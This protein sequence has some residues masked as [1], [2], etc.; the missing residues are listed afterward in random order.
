M[1]GTNTSYTVK[2]W[3]GNKVAMEAGKNI[4]MCEVFG[5]IKESEKA[6]YAVLNIGSYS[7]KTMW[8]PKSVLVAN[9]IGKDGQGMM[10]YETMRFDSYDEAIEAFNA[11]WDM[12]N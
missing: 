1:T 4:S 3:F 6:V 8:V 10:H 9:E 5:I 7:R 2:E 11:H 12:F